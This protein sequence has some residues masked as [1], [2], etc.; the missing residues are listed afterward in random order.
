M[1]NPFYYSSFCSTYSFD[2]GQLSLRI[3]RA[4]QEIIEE[5]DELKED[6]NEKASQPEVFCLSLSLLEVVISQGGN[7]RKFIRRTRES[8]LLKELHKL[9]VSTI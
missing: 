7:C 8:T 5:L 9:F 1:V 6:T 2:D 4:P 3:S